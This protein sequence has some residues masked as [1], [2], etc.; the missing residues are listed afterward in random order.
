[1]NRFRPALLRLEDIGPGGPYRTLKDLGRLRAVFEYLMG[2]HV[3]FHVA[4]IPRWK[5][6]EP[7]SSWY[8]KGL[9][10]STPDLH[11]QKFISLMQCVQRHGV[12]FGMHG[13]THQYGDRKLEND[14]QDTGTGF[15][16]DVEGF[17]ETATSFY[18]A[19]RIRK[20]LTAFQKAGLYPHFWESPHYRHTLAQERIFGSYVKVLYQSDAE[21]HATSHVYISETG[22]I[23]IPT[24]YYYVHEQN[25]VAQILS[26]LAGSHD[27][28]SM[29]YHP[30]LE[31]PHLEPVRDSVGSPLMWDG[32]PV[33][34]Y[35]T[36]DTDLQ[37]L[38][39]GVRHMRY[40]WLP[41][42]ALIPMPRVW[43]G[44]DYH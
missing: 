12:L 13:Y 3:P 28:A 19:D 34:R 35:K 1:M 6:L 2:Q 7:D 24:P 27:L 11:L 16:F 36:E 29:F 21:R 44:D 14:N 42:Y 39:K 43:Q 37:R 20:S 33:Y 10:D 4:L 15:E 9:D 17:P 31:F 8:N 41:L 26:R 5:Q 38:V 18:A 23:F 32:L 22:N 25:T 40:H 30:F